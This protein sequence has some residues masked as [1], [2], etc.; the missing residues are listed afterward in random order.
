MIM[1]LV[2]GG[3]EERHRADLC[4]LLDRGEEALL[5]FQFGVVAAKEFC[6]PKG[7]VIEPFPQGRRWADITKPEID[8][9]IFL[10][11]PSGP[12]P[13]D[14]HTEPIGLASRLIDTFDQDAHGRREPT[15]C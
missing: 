13:V 9:S 8:A 2:F 7:I 11:E 4:L 3:I 12:E 14:Q 1:L 15:D 5:R 6:P 10:R